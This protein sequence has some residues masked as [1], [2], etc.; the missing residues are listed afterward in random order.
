MEENHETNFPARI[1]SPGIAIGNAL[2][3]IEP[4]PE[5][6]RTQK[7]NVAAE[8]KRFQRQ[9][10][11]I[12]AE[13]S[14]LFQKIS[15]EIDSKDAAII[16]T[17]VM[18]LTDVEFRKKVLNLIAEEF[19]S[20]DAAVERVMQHAYEKLAASQN[21]YMRARADDFLDLSRYFKRQS[22]EWHGALL[23]NINNDTVLIVSEFYPSMILACNKRDSIK[24]IVAEK[25]VPIS[26]AAILA[27]SFGLPV[28]VGYTNN[29]INIGAPVIIDGLKGAI[30]VNPTSRTIDSYQ[31][32]SN[33][34]QIDKA[35]IKKIT[36]VPAITSDGTRIVLG[37][38]IERLDELPLIHPKEID[39]IGLLRSEFLFMYDQDDFPAFRKQVQ[40]Y[41]K[42]VSYLKDKPVVIRIL[43]IGGDK[44]L[45]YLT[46]A[47]QGNPY[48]GLRAHRVFRFHPE[49]LET[50]LSAILQASE[51]GR[52]K[53]LYPMI[54]TLEELDFLNN[55]LSKLKKENDRPLEIGMMVET[56]ASVFM[57]RELLPKVDF[58]S[59][60]TND[61]VQ[62]ALTVDRNNE[63]VMDYYQPMNPVIVRMI[64]EVVSA[65]A[66]SGKPVTLCGEIAADP[67]WTPLLIG[68]GIR[69]LSMTPAAILPV[70][71]RL[72][73]LDLK[74]CT[75]L[76]DAVLV[77]SYEKD[78]RQL[79]EN[80]N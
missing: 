27:R 48:L 55:I 24:G 62:Y 28:V 69:S 61:L 39:E 23:N 16:E 78:I 13:L 60:G 49:I 35:E 17:Q 3:V 6:N 2:L 42:A 12:A 33:A 52:V 29:K 58:V 47:R 68:M 71:K 65:A 32:R 64:H 75:K 14:E 54:N 73:S 51:F 11:H 80:F 66:E 67:I 15:N 31:N 45:P 37:A 59:I 72:I 25:G 53:I 9:V 21:D 22:W 34:I 4:F 1:I 79:L 36:N 7:L 63:D 77:A 50:Q 38:N 74:A 20:V 40:W 43:D 56:P 30:V 10:D 26:H 46:I 44:F 18:I 57:I 5:S 70:K 8:I 19:L 76:A 41:R